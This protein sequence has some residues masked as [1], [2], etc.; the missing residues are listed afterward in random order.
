MPEISVVM[1]VYNG[2]EGLRLTLHSVLSQTFEDFEFIVVDDGST[3]CTPRVLEECASEDSRIVIVRQ[4]NKGLTNA[5]IRGCSLACGDFIARQDAG[6][7]SMPD[8][9]SLQK[10]LLDSN[11][12]AVMVASGAIFSAPEGEELFETTMPGIQLDKGIR[13]LSISHIKG[14]PHHGGTM[15]RRDAYLACG[16]YRPQFRVAQDIDLWLR[17][18]ERGI[19]LGNPEVLYR[20][21]VEP[22][23]ISITRADEQLHFGTLAIRSALQRRNGQEESSLLDQSLPDS[24]N[25][26]RITSHRE[27]DYYYFVAST[28]AKKNPVA[29]RKYLAK[30]LELNRWHIK[31]RIR[32]LGLM[33]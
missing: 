12:G 1:G 18:S 5:L 23:S 21:S 32:S 14:P 13:Q 4:A 30:T 11:P 6:D 29:A 7:V 9:L 33:R 19:C 22:G 28:L 16:G 25:R 24:V 10:Q 8:R 3:D 2:K 20:A 15:F 27:A 17:L 31:A 26:P